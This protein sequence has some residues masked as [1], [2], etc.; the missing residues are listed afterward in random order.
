MLGLDLGCGMAKTPG[1][2]GV[3]RLPL[4]GVNVVCDLARFPWPFADN[5]VGRLVFN[6]SI[7]YLGPFAQLLDELRRVCGSGALIE[8]HSPHFSSY[9]YFSDPLYWFP[10]AWR[11]FDFWSSVSSFKYNYY[12]D[13]AFALEILK[14]KITFSNGPNPWR[15]VGIEAFAN[16]FPRFYERFCASVLPAQEIHF[17]LKLIKSPGMSKVQK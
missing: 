16:R 17:K 14:R 1:T 5:S 6:H 4:R 15:W 7:Q 11:T 12:G 2:I 9:N 3:D 10:L 13:R 8:I